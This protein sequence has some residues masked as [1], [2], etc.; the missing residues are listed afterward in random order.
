MFRLLFFL[1][2]GWMV[3]RS[4]TCVSSERK[5]YRGA[6]APD[7]GLNH[8]LKSDRLGMINIPISRGT[9]DHSS[10][11]QLCLPQIRLFPPP[12]T[13][14]LHTNCPTY[15]W[16]CQKPA[17]GFKAPFP[18]SSFWLFFQTRRAKVNGKSPPSPE[19]EHLSHHH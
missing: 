9:P 4:L 7:V 11:P 18:C 10:P 6:A 12:T 1:V 14:R 16:T 2:S 17:R 8:Q 5:T 19:E 13:R 3:R 15:F